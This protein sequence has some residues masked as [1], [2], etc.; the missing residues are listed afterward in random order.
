MY[1][2][3]PNAIMHFLQCA[4]E[5]YLLWSSSCNYRYAKLEQSPCQRLCPCLPTLFYIPVFWICM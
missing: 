3:I 2:L 5:L 1:L 4:V